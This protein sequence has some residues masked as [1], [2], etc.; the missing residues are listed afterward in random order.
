[1]LVE[2][3]TAEKGSKNY[4]GL[5]LFRGGKNMVFLVIGKVIFFLDSVKGYW[6]LI[7]VRQLI[8]NFCVI[9]SAFWSILNVAGI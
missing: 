1:L 9:F 4:S 2:F 8:E 6:N 3:Q 7:V 5:C